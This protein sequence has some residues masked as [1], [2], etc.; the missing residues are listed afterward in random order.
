MLNFVAAFP[1]IML[2]LFDRCL[3]KEY[4]K[5]NP[6]VYKATKDNE[7]ITFRTLLRW[8]LTVFMHLFTLYYF[9][10]PPQ[11]S[12]GGMTSS[13]VGLMRNEDEDTPGNGEG[14]DLKS[15]GTVTFTCMII[16]LAYKVLYESKSLLHG[17]WPAFTCKTGVKEGFFSRCAYTW[18]S[19]T[20]GS[21][22]FY[23]WAIALYQ[24]MGRLFTS[25]LSS[26]VDVTNHVLGT[27]SMSWMLITFVPIFGM[28]FDVS[29][30]VF[31][32][33]FY[34]TQTQ[35]HLEVESKERGQRRLQRFEEKAMRNSRRVQAT[36]PDPDPHGLGEQVAL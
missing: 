21:I 36:P 26:F 29:I 2:G 15:G 13:F 4:V 27:R 34:P 33:M 16:L 17:R 14:G 3:S 28:A 1:I 31:S 35:I 25:S 11:G 18:Q 8:V 20:F 32:N 19:I 6:E 22:G 9:T 12:G 5:R 30:K 10:V 24:V 23:L 7:L